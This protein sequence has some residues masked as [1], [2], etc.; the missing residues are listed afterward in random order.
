MD[1]LLH[2]LYLSTPFD[3]RRISVRTPTAKL[4]ASC[5]ALSKSD[6]SVRK[7][8]IVRAHFVEAAGSAALARC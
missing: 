1:R 6:Y 4:A 8:L 7:E 3:D 5:G 2:S